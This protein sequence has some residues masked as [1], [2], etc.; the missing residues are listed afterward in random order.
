ML[1][2]FNTI[3]AASKVLTPLIP[4]PAIGHDPQPYY[5]PPVLTVYLPKSILMLT[6]DLLLSLPRR[7]F[8][9]HFPSKIPHFFPS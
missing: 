1:V 5:P 9:R 2:I 4:K 8:P 3:A 6:S 7:N